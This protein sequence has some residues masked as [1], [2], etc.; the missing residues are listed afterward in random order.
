MGGRNLSWKF[1]EILFLNLFQKV[2]ENLLSSSLNVKKE[3]KSLRK[4]HEIGLR[5]IGL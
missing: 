1:V 5:I 2:G 4:V 3:P